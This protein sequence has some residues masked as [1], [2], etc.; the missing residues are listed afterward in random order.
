MGLLHSIEKGSA[1]PAAASDA[2]KAVRAALALLQSTTAV[3]PALDRA[4][5]SVA[6]SLSAIHALT[7]AAPPQAAVPAQP[8]AAAVVRTEPVHPVR[9]NPAPVNPA[10]ANPA[11]TAPVNTAQPIPLTRVVSE[12]APVHALEPAVPARQP[13][14]LAASAGS[15]A[16]QPPAA[17]SDETVVQAALGTHSPSNF[18]KGL[19]GND[20]LE[21]GGLFIAT[22]NIPDIG[23]KL[24]VDVSLPG[25][26]E[27]SAKAVVMW[28]RDAPSSSQ[29]AT[30]SPPG[31]GVR[32]TD[33][34]AE[35]RQLVYRYVRNREPLFHDDF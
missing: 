31:Y 12:P 30:L 13:A 28:S 4:M 16:H 34:S 6:G 23:E 19:N 27:F 33:I 18:Y 7:T 29:N 14:P 21:S 15:A 26:F 10:P 22:Y 9:V 20:V 25:G 11:P 35:G 24:R 32:L 1:A 8:Q 2:L 5:E 3:H 17:S